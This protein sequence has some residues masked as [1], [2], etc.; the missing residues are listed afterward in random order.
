MKYLRYLVVIIFIGIAGCSPAAMPGTN[1]STASPT[2][3]ATPTATAPPTPTPLRPMPINPVKG[4]AA[5]FSPAP[6]STPVAGELAG[7]EATVQPI[8]R[9]FPP[10]ATTNDTDC[11]AESVPPYRPPAG[12][13]D[14]PVASPA[15]VTL[16]SLAELNGV[17][18]GAATA[19]G[20][21]NIPE[22]L[23]LLTREFNMVAT[24]NAMKW[25]VLH[26]EPG[27]YDFTEGDQ[28]VKIADAHRLPVYGHVLA[29]GLQNPEWVEKGTFTRDEWLQ[30]LCTHIKTVVG[31]YRGHIYAWDVV[32]EAITDEGTLRDNV[33]LRNIGPEYI[34]LAFRWAYEADPQALLIYNDFYAEDLNTKSEAVYGL[35]RELREAGIPIH[36]IG[37]QMHVLIDQPPDPGEVL[38][39]MQRISRLGLQAHITEMDVRTYPSDA[40]MAEKMAV[41]AQI[42]R[43]MLGVCLQAANCN[44][45]ITWGLADNYSW[46]PG[47]FGY[48]D[49]PLLFDEQG[50]PKPAYWALIDL[51]MGK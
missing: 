46:I 47:T 13:M 28:I 41:E 49:A 25:E 44:V 18:V 23:E 38:A 10:G 11:A 9:L 35:A 17:F 16:R 33:W 22:Y 26:P 45:F 24:E 21:L 43:Q 19:P 32:N 34:P 48:P 5:W 50:Q 36:G 29:W 8:A 4:R 27:R 15:G 7:A 51:L 1:T 14:L 6:T 42:Y 40:P 39:N 3:T 12:A 20:W 37:M 2:W 30:I 31:H